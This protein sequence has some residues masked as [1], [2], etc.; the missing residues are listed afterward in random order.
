MNA[1]STDEL[2][3]RVNARAVRERFNLLLC[4][5]KTILK[6]ENNATGISPEST[7][8]DEALENLLERVN[9]CEEEQMQMNKENNDRLENDKLAAEDI[10]NKAL[11]TFS[12]TK[13]R[14]RILDAESP[15][16]REQKRRSGSDT[17]Q[18]LRDKAESDREVRME[19][20]EIQRPDQVMQ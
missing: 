14:K 5:Y 19:Q 8:L 16:E 17:L 20:S 10:R 2:Y 9:A 7:P 4:Q 11:E 3:F 18:Y 13:A 15:K 1:G 12:E 6:D